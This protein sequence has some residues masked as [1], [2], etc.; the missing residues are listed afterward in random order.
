MRTQA[1]LLT[2][3]GNYLLDGSP[4]IFSG[5]IIEVLARIPVGEHAVR[6]TLVRMVRRGLLERHRVGKR[7][8]LGLTPYGVQVL[9]AGEQRVRDA[10]DH[11]WDG[12]WTLLAFSMPE[13]RR[14]D[15]H[16]LRSRLAWNGFGLVQHGLWITSAPVDTDQLVADLGLAEHIRV[17]RAA[18]LPPTDLAEMISSAWD[19]DKVDAGYRRFL[20]R[21]D[22]VDPLPSAGDDLARQLLLLTE[23]L[24]LVRADPRL[25]LKHL[26]ADW[27]GVRAEQV[28]TRLRSTYARPARALAARSLERLPDVP[29]DETRLRRRGPSGPRR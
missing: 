5:S 25:P 14:A 18:V 16:Q 10:V 28:L 8:Y 4:P 20:E 21:W 13:D 1:L 11:R 7:V 15:R 29:G 24:L 22:V 23:W 2:F 9:R 19:L 3:F 26:P 27:P 12:H 17:F 6:S